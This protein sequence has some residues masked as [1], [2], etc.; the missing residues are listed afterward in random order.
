M[1]KLCQWFDV[2]RRTTYYKPTKGAAKF[3]A[4]LAESIREVIEAEPSFG[5]RTVAALLGMNKNTVQ[6]VF[7]LKGWH[8][9]NSLLGQR[10][11]MEVAVSRAEGLD[12]RWA[13]DPVP[14]LRRQGRLAEPGACTRLRDATTAWLASV[15]NRQGQERIDRAGTSSHRTLRH[16]LPPFAA[17]GQRPDVDQSRLY[18]TG[19][20]LWPEVGVHTPH[21]PQ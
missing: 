1:T 12:Q 17:L 2:S 10:P 6:R 11:R 8:V 14:S 18:A 20:T 9:R 21:C 7:Q 15:A 19:A 13:T 5:Y 16:V 3:K 4:E